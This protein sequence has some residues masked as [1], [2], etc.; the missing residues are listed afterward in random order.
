[1]TDISPSSHTADCTLVSTRT[2]VQ[3]LVLKCLRELLDPLTESIRL[4]IRCDCYSKFERGESLVILSANNGDYTE[5]RIPKRAMAYGFGMVL[6]PC[7]RGQL[8]LDSL[9]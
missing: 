9:N 8:S 2:T 6:L 1:M 3:N 7:P 4:A 5:L